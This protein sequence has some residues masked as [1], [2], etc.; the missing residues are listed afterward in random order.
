MVQAFSTMTIRPERP[1]DASRVRHVNELA[2]GQPMEADLVERLRQGCTDSLSL[3][4]EDDAVVGHILFTPVAIESEERRVLGMGLAPMA[5]LPGRQRQGIGSQLV[6]RGL[7]ILRERGCP[8]VVVIGHP[9]YYPRFGFEPAS[10]HRLASQWDGV[11]DAAF[12]VQ[13]LDAYA[14][15]GVSGVAK[16]RDE[17]SEITREGEMIERHYLEDCLLQLRKLK[18]L[19]DN[20]IGQIEDERLFAVLDPEANSIAVI[21]KHMAGNMRSRWTDFLTSDGEKPDRDRDRE[22]ELDSEDTRAKILSVWDEGWKHALQSV[23]SLSPEDLGKTI[24]IR[25]EGHSVVEA[26]NRQMT[27]YAAHVGQIVL[28]AKHYAG[29]KWRSL[30]IPR[31]KSKEFDV[32]KS[33]A[34]YSVARDVKRSGA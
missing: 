34:A 31:G 27:H 7:D 3:V 6:R 10:T 19:A 17:F 12:M 30:S 28:L 13:I 26:I 5:V 24:R 29:P 14:M 32:A 18:E 16:Y 21:M 11:P 23:S 25:G 15:A 9:E 20:A 33:G 1:E 8:F 2:F 4:A 22:F